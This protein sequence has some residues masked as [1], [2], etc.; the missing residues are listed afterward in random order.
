M[1][2]GRFWQGRTGSALLGWFAILSLVVISL[3]TLTLCLV[4]GYQLEKNMLEWE[5]SAT[6]DFIRTEARQ[7]LSPEDFARPTTPE[8]QARFRRFYEEAVMMPRIVRVKIYDADARVIWSDETRLIGQRFDN[9]QLAT[10]LTGHISVNLERTPK[11]ENVYEPASVGLV[12]VYVPVMYPG[13]VGVAGVVETYKDLAQVF[14]NIRQG[15]LTVVSTAVGGGVVLYL[16]LFW[17]V[18]HAARR[19]ESQHHALQQRSRDLATTNEELTVVQGQ[20]LQAERLAAIGE[21]V[22][23]VA[24]GIRNPLANIRASAQVALLDCEPA[25]ASEPTRSLK[26]I[27]AEVDRL[28]GCVRELLQF[29][30]PAERRTPTHGS[31]GHRPSGGAIVPR[32]S[33]GSRRPR[34]GAAGPLTAAD[35]R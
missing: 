3:T 29:V 9:P 35:D 18:R 6:A 2:L 5:W 34:R 23:A 1:S 21:V 7:W 32:T 24:H 19:I 22:T 11:I 16:S 15:Q 10:A 30:R 27:M 12:E 17:I 20:L 13:Q 28:E 14:A 31:G 33:R 8:A 4:I 25:P 26:N